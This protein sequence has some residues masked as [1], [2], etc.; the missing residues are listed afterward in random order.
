MIVKTFM[1]LVSLLVNMDILEK[2]DEKIDLSNEPEG[3]V[4]QLST[5]ENLVRNMGYVITTKNGNVIVIDGGNYEDGAN[6]ERY[7]KENGGKVDSWY[8]THY[9]SDHTGAFNYVIENTDVEIGRVYLSLNSRVKVEK[10]ERIR[11]GDYDKYL[12]TLQNS[13]LKRKNRRSVCWTNFKA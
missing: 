4:I 13:K 9:H 10:Y 8:I 7:I 6:L 2:V 12:K 3:T 11:L 5:K 1:L